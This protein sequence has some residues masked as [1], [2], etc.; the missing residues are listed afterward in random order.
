MKPLT[1][2]SLKSISQP[3]LSRKLETDSMSRIS[4]VYKI[5]VPKNFSSVLTSKEVD[6]NLD[7]DLKSNKYL[8][9]HSKLQAMTSKNLAKL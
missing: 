5:S 9:S 1:A 8:L 3:R 4:S 2:N 6:C 7:N